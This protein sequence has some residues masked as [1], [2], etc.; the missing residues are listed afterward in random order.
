MSRFN[1]IDND[2]KSCKPSILLKRSRNSI[3][4]GKKPLSIL[5]FIVVHS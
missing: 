5:N 4:L 2:R 3:A 1:G